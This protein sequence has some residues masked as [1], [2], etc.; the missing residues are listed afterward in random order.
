MDGGDADGR[1]RKKKGRGRSDQVI[2]KD[3]ASGKPGLREG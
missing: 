2:R 1:E 3:P